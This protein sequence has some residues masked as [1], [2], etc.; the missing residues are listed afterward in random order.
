MN[1]RKLMTMSLAALMAGP[2]LWTADAYAEAKIGV[3]AAIRG[4]VFVRSGAAADQRRASV[5]ESIL[6]QDEVLTKQQSALQILLL[7]ESV[8]TI[9]ENCEM[10]IDRFVYDPDQKAGEM[11]GKVLK[12]AFRFMSG[13]IGKANPT[14]ANIETPSATI[15]IRGTM[16][17]GVV[18]EDAIKLAKLLGFSTDSA[19]SGKALLVVLR[20]PGRGTNSLSNNGIIRVGNGAGTKTI[21]SPNYAVFVPGPGQAPIGPIKITD[22][23]LEYFDFYLR[24]LPN[25]PAF[26]GDTETGEGLSGQDSF[27]LPGGDFPPLNDLFDDEL[28][29]NQIPEDMDECRDE[30]CYYEEYEYE[31]T[32]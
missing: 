32:D 4:K 15:G 16:F 30:F 26:R 6:L 11:S 12:G 7:D 23:I 18:G 9:G 5:D 29:D 27:N 24:T 21:S 20:G 8:F 1:A 19:D 31:F 28:F 17:E 22:A 13:R 10:I 2:L 3:S 14:K 25:G